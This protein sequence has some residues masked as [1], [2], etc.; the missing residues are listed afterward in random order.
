MGILIL[1]RIYEAKVLNFAIDGRAL[2][3]AAVTGGEFTLIPII[4]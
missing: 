3:E 4:S 1:A 2:G